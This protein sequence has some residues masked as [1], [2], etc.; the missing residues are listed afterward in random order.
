MID[1]FHPDGR[2]RREQR[3]SLVTS[4][5]RGAS[6]TSRG[7]RGA[8]SGRDAG[9]RA[10]S[11]SRRGWRRSRGA[12]GA[13]RG[14]GRGAAARRTPPARCARG[15]GR[16]IRKTDW[17]GA[18]ESGRIF[19]GPVRA[20]GADERATRPDATS[21]RARDGAR[22][23]PDARSRLRARRPIPPARAASPARAPRPSRGVDKTKNTLRAEA[24]IDF[25]RWRDRPETHPRGAKALTEEPNWVR[26]PEAA[27]RTFERRTAT[28]GAAVA[29]T[30]GTEQMAAIVTGV[31][32]ARARALA[33]LMFLR[34]RSARSCQLYAGETAVREPP[35]KRWGAGPR[36]RWPIRTQ[37]RGTFHTR[38]WPSLIRTQTTHA[39]DEWVPPRMI[40][41]SARS[42][43][44]YKR[45]LAPS[46]PRRSLVTAWRAFFPPLPPPPSPLPP[47]PPL[48]ARTPPARAR[49]L[50]RT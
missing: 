30:V 47:P 13:R 39:G 33:W 16:P 37:S 23:R 36:P 40:G 9:A 15:G 8:R 21:E 1:I 22:G 45:S 10:G 32:M 5:D 2:P 28:L 50:C 7:A 6:V 29:R 42:R 27:A 41:Q 24:R 25:A 48:P 12:G 35:K 14:G 34:E 31:I 20:D 3:L 38:G 43:M 26:R 4:I 49:G 46:Q 19:P 17:E 11:G 44:E 18:L